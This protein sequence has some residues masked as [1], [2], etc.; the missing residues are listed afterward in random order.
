MELG[1]CA[2]TTGGSPVL[3]DTKKNIA[4]RTTERTIRFFVKEHEK[5]K[6]LHPDDTL[7][8][9]I[10]SLR[11]FGLKPSKEFRISLAPRS[12][13]V[14]EAKVVLW[15]YSSN[16]YRLLRSKH[17]PLIFASQGSCNRELALPV[18]RNGPDVSVTI[19]LGPKLTVKVLPTS[20][21]PTVASPTMAPPPRLLPIQPLLKVKSRAP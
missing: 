19:K 21:V 20:T 16:P 17:V 18:T 2:W 14:L 5:R 10:K 13:T 4:R 3:H 8:T 11:N 12:A 6:K 9:R 7:S 1:D 15:G